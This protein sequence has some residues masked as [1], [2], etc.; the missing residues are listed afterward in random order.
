MAEGAQQ[1]SE[2]I[3]TS[4]RRRSLE[5]NYNRAQSS[6]DVGHDLEGQS[7]LVKTPASLPCHISVT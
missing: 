2:D 7:H 3:N 5:E 6:V 1:S 4:W